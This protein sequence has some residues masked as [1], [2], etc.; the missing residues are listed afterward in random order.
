[1]LVMWTTEYPA[2]P[3]RELVC[4]QQ[5]VG[6]YG[7]ALAVYPLGLDGVQPRT[8]LGQKAAYDPH[9]AAAILDVAIVLAEP[10]PDLLGDVPGG[11]VPEIRSRTFF[12][13]ASS[14]SKHH[15]RNCVVI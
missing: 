7:L 10:A 14:F 13:L 12:P 6:F 9:S 4:S 5:T 1:M 3:I 8:L 2:D 11:V 15:P